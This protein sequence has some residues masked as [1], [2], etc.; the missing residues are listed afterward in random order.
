M[1]APAPSTNTISLPHPTAPALSTPTPPS[2]TAPPPLTPSAPP[3][4][5]LRITRH[6]P[7]LHH[8]QRHRNGG[9]A[10][11]VLYRLQIGMLRLAQNRRFQVLER[12]IAQHTRRQVPQQCRKVPCVQTQNAVIFQDLQQHLPRP[13]FSPGLHVLRDELLWPRPAPA[14][15][16]E[17]QSK[18][19]GQSDS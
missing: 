16:S 13:P 8:I 3:P 11:H 4:A 9:P 14:T 15:D 1:S 18:Q 17:D 5:T 2:S 7:R 6:Q 19:Q 10:H 12:R